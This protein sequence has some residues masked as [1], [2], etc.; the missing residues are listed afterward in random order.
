MLILS[1]SL[2]VKFLGEIQTRHSVCCFF[3]LKVGQQSGEKVNNS[4]LVLKE[5]DNS[6]ELV[7]PFNIQLS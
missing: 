4:L 3:Y 1:K 7:C 6:S 5:M 2:E